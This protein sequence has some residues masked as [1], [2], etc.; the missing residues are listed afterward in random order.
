[1]VLGGFRSFHVLVTTSSIFPYINH[2]HSPQ[3]L[4]SLRRRANARNVSFESLYGGRFQ[5]NSV[6]EVEY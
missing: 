2:A 3:F 6:H 4:D 5:C 1:M